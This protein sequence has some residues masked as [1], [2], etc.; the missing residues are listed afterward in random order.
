[1]SNTTEEEDKGILEVL[2][3]RLVKQRLPHALALEKKVDQGD[4]LNDYDIQF[5]AE[6]L[7]DIGRAKPVYDRHPDY[8]PLIAKLMSLYAHIIERGAENEGEQAS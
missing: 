4:V 7:R 1:M 8:Q 2:L 5:L 6:V 3:E